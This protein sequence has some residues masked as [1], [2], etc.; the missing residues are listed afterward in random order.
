MPRTSASSVESPRRVTRYDVGETSLCFSSEEC[1]ARRFPTDVR[2]PFLYQWPATK[3][4]R[5]NKDNNKHHEENVSD[6]RRF[7]R[8]TTESQDLRDNRYDQK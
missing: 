5:Q 6:P 7:A 8:H 3:Q 1:K 4:E 2:R